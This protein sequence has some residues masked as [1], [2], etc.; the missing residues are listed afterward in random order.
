[1]PINVLYFGS[2]FLFYPGIRRT[3]SADFTRTLVTSHWSL[4]RSPSLYPSRFGVVYTRSVKFLSPLQTLSVDD[5]GLVAPWL[6]WRGM[7]LVL[8]AKLR[9]VS[10]E[11][12]GSRREIYG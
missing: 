6:L 9:Q 1:M 12:L 7:L 3:T 8:S 10:V 2:Q 4:S 11:Q 5:L